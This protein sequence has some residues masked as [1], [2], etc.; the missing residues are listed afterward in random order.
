MFDAV[1]DTPIPSENMFPGNVKM[2]RWWE[3]V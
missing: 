3:T 2:E 1:L